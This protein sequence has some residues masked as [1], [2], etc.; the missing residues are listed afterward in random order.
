M[1]AGKGREPGGARL[2][3]VT[4]IRRLTDSCLL[5]TD[6]RGTTIID[7]GF[8]TFQHDGTDLATIGDV[9]RVLITHEHRD[10]VSPEFVRW[11]IDRGDDVR[12]HANDR[13][14]QL[15]AGH[16]IDVSTED[17]EGVTSEDVLHEV[18][19][20]GDAPPNRS[21]SLGGTITHPGDS[22]QPTTSEQV[23]ALSLIS[24]W[25]SA[26]ES[27]AFARRLTPRQVVPIHDFYTSASGREWLVGLI[28]GVLAGVGIDLVPL[29]WGDGYT[30]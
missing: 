15:L 6:D 26:T 25:G 16:D 28:K 14:A 3:A 7:P 17:P 11:L 30:L 5:V 18:V 27:V 12:V 10:H 4:T 13:V 1:T 20:T 8:F 23:L 24:P 29:D 9:Q 19:P 21:W 22:Y 2:G